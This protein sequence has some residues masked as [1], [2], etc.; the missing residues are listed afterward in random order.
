MTPGNVDDR[1][2]RQEMTNGP[3]FKGNRPIP[4]EEKNNPL[5]RRVSGL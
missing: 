5:S 1:A 2:F 4:E 3:T